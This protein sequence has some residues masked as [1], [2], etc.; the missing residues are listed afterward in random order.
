MEKYLEDAKSNI[1]FYEKM[2]LDINISTKRN[3][4]M[5][6]KVSKKNILFPVKVMS[7]LY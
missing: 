6:I 1:Q 2:M 4:C 3:L 5:I 7:L